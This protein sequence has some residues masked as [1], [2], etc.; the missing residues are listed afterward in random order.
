MA[1][2]GIK[3]QCVLFRNPAKS[4][5]RARVPLRHY[6]IIARL[7]Y[8]LLNPDGYFLCLPLKRCRIPLYLMLSRNQIILP[9]SSQRKLSAPLIYSSKLTVTPDE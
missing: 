2:G 7:H 3:D 5:L 9:V 1:R 8:L 4:K 6:A